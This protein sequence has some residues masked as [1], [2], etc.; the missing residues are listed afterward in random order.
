MGRLRQALRA[1]LQSEKE[2]RRFG[3]GWISGVFALF[4]AMAGL[5]AV[6]CLRFPDLLTTPMLREHLGYNHLREED[7]VHFVQEFPGHFQLKLV[8]L[9]EFDRDDKSFAADFLDKRVLGT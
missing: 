9:M 3:S 2:D 8:R 1:D 7:L 5:I 6:L 4:F